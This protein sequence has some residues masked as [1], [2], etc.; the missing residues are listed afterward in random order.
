[1][2]Q[3]PVRNIA[4][5]DLPEAGPLPHKRGNK[6]ILNIGLGGNISMSFFSRND[7]GRGFRMLPAAL[8][9]LCLLGTPVAAQDR[10]APKWE[11]FGGYSFFHPGADVHGTLPLGLVP[12]TSRLEPNPRGAG[13]SATYNFSRWF[14]LT[15]DASSNWGAGETTLARRIDDAGFSNISLG[16]KI[17]FRHEHFSIFMEGLVGDHRLMPDA[18]HDIDKLGFMGGGGLDINLSRHVALR[19]IRADYVFSNYR[20]GAPATT[21]ETQ[22]RGARLQSGLVLMWGGGPPPAPP[23]ATCAVDPAEVFAGET[24]AARSNGAGFNPKRTV[25]YNWSGSGV[26]VAGADASTQIDTTGLEPGSYPVAANLSDGSKTGIASCSATFTVKR[27]RPPMVSCSA[28]PQTI[29][30]GGTATVRADA[31]SPDKRRLTYSY[32][33]SAGSVSGGDASATLNSAGAQ[34][35]PITV[36]CMVSDDRNPALRASA[37]TTVMVEAPPPPAPPAEI[38]ELEGKLALHSIYFQ[39]ARPTEKDPGGG[40]MDS[41]QTVLLA[42][43]TDFNRYLTYRSDAHLTL[44]G[45]ADQRG[46]TAYN[47]ALTERRVNRAKNFLVEHGVPAASIQIQSFG[48]DQNLN[49]EQIR[50]QMDAN[51]DLSE[52]DRNKMRSNLAVIVLANNRRVD[53]ALSTTGQQSVRRYPFNA[54][55]ALALISTTGIEKKPAG[56]K[57]PKKK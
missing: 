39:T 1:M 27:P 32:T 40:L 48:K 44:S 17:T 55:D 43:A 53:I 4:G 3:L 38:G 19:L 51:P 37:T 45:H 57:R 34:A 56:K 20:Y 49:A 10:P 50:E 2:S 47:Q 11:L 15:L 9:V 18:F 41:Q 13:V 16:P 30:M 5:V 42:L 28:D 31:N 52:A 8:A 54:K 29:M 33:A 24:V 35:G 6:K 25:K 23:T 26:K 22:I 12:L 7:L 14:G 21:P 36:N 46:S